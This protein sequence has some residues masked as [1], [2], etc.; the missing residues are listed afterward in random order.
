MNWTRKLRAEINGAFLINGNVRSI[1]IGAGWLDRRRPEQFACI[2]EFLQS[3]GARARDVDMSSPIGHETLSDRKVGIGHGES[4]HGF[5][6]LVKR[7]DISVTR[8]AV[9]VVA[10]A[11]VPVN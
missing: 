2:G 7:S 8:F 4:P 3:D 1:A 5:A 9:V 11:K 10:V 6:R